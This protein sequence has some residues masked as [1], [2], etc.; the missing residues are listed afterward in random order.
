MADSITEKLLVRR[1]HLPH[2]QAGGSIYDVTFCS[3][4]GPLPDPARRQ[5]T[6]NILFDHGKRFDLI[7][8]VVM[9]NHVHLLLCPRTCAPGRWYDL[10]VIMKGIKGVSARRIN[11]LLGTAGKVCQ[12]ESY[13]RII[14][15][16][17]ELEEKVNYIWNNP[18]K[19][20][21]AANP[22]EYEFFVYPP[23]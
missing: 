23:R 21:L 10:A 5:V 1:A 4:R 20:G 22:E 9:P 6:K 19:A 14:R 7:F 13:D 17:Q 15:S 18:V 11:Q 16:E 12:Q 2:W 3:A 8:G